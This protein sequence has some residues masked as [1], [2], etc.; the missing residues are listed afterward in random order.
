[1]TLYN[2][3]MDNLTANITFYFIGHF[4]IDNIIRFNRSHNPS[5]GGTV[6]FGSLGLRSYSKK[7][8]I[9]I[10]S[11]LGKLNF[12]LSFLN[13]FKKKNINLEGLKWF[14]SLNTNFI[15]NYLDHSRTLTLKSK[16]PNLNFE[17]IPNPYL[18]TKPDVIVLAPICNEI[19]EDYVSKIVSEFPNAYIGIDL[20]GFIRNISDNGKIDY[21]S[22]EDLLKR[23]YKMINLI[24][25]RLVL[26]GSEDEMK[27]LTQAEDF[28][29]IMAFFDKFENK[30]IYI[31][32]LGEKGSIIKKPKD[33]I[34]KI[35]AFNPKKV[36][37]ET[38]AGDVYLAIFLYEFIYSNRAWDAIERAAYL[39][40]AAASFLVE[41]NGPKGFKSKKEVLKRVN[42]KNY[43]NY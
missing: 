21:I 40:S 7:V 28:S 25:N 39:A 37:D 15:L 30:G 13:S 23:I 20:Q 4:A 33:K 1:M 22:N 14:D 42:A 5:L 17:D 19:S 36:V 24:G 9:G 2:E 26:K 3:D 18:I 16:S 27:L 41:K 12:R 6:T 8:N 29:E 34:L 43:I 35:P 10:I 32:T 11:N 38:G 31:M